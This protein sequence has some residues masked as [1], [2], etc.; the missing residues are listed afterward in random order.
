[1]READLPKVMK[2]RTV[3]AR[4]A[5]GQLNAIELQLQLVPSFKSAPKESA[6]LI[7]PCLY[8]NPTGNMRMLLGVL[9]KAEH[10]L[11]RTKK[12]GTWV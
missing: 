5:A 3:D 12:N 7:L 4:Q 11:Q 8:T 10:K 6:Y 1:M 9:N 2:N